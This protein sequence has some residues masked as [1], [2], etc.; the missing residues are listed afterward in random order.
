M[1]HVVVCCGML[2]YVEGRTESSAPTKASQSSRPQTRKNQIIFLTTRPPRGLPLGVRQKNTSRL[3]VC[4]K[5]ARTPRVLVPLRSAAQS[6]VIP[7]AMKLK[8]SLPAYRT[9]SVRPSISGGQASPST[10]RMV[11]AMSASRPWRSSLP[12]PQRIK[13]TGL[14]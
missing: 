9:I 13:G 5:D 8:I 6:A 11:G 2:W 4:P 10:S 12:A 14:V 3:Q 7:L 1:K